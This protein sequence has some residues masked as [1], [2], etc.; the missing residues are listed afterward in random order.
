MKNIEQ[1]YWDVVDFMLFRAKFPELMFK[2]NESL[3]AIIRSQTTKLIDLSLQE[4]KVFDDK[5][6]SVR[7]DE[8]KLY[9][10]KLFAEVD[11]RTE[12]MGQVQSVKPKK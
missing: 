2:E 10:N 7:L 3:C 4:N 12:D 11:K 9:L 6:F 8:Y 1:K 5:P